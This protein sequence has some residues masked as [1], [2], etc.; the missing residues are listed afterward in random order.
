[1][2]H[3]NWRPWLCSAALGL[4]VAGG[5]PGPAGLGAVTAARADEGA[6]PGVTVEQYCRSWA[7]NGMMGAQVHQHGG[8]REIHY[9]DD[10][11]LR[12]LLKHDA[13]GDNLYLMKEDYTPA[14]KRYLEESLL[15][16]FDR[17]EKWVKEHPGETG[18]LTGW[19]EA[20]YQECLRTV[21]E[22]IRALLDH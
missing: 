13:A 12:Y 11:Q 19:E 22:A 4:C 18:D 3:R 16:G 7:R 21:P 15:A 20:M 14:Q 6:S 2:R 1:M 9:I 17:R 10:N 8:Q 5:L